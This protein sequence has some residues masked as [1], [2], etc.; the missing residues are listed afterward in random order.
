MSYDLKER[1]DQFRYIKI[2]SNTIDPRTRLWGINPTNSVFIP[3]SL[4]LRSIVLGWILIY[5]NWSISL[6]I[7]YFHNLPPRAFCLFLFR[8]AHNPRKRPRE[9]CCHFHFCFFFG[10]VFVFVLL[11]YVWN[12]Y[13]FFVCLI[14]FLNSNLTYFSRNYYYYYSMFGMFHVPGFI[15][16]RCCFCRTTSKFAPNFTPGK[17]FRRTKCN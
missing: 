7:T 4:A 12:R 5:R 2:Q 1:I 17:Q 13:Q 3:Q 10:Y 14:Y 9:R 11:F 6:S 8:F 15:D 16:A